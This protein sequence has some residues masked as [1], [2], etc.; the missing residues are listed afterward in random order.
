[1]VLS[2]LL[3]TWH[4]N[5]PFLPWL[6]RRV[7]CC[8][9]ACPNNVVCNDHLPC[10]E[11]SETLMVAQHRHPRDHSPVKTLGAQSVI[12]RHSAHILLH[13]SLRRS[14][15]C[16]PTPIEGRGHQKPVHGFLQTPPASFLLADSVVCPSAVISLGHGHNSMLRP[17]SPS[18][19]SLN[20]GAISGTPDTGEPRK[21]GLS[22]NPIKTVSIQ[23]RNQFIQY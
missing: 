6:R 20:V 4:L 10:S 15:V 1:M 13:L 18:S 23:N 19:E 12:G 17:V 22:G 9:S 3:G 16:T 2:Q 14:T 7:H 11:D 8:G 21:W 5:H